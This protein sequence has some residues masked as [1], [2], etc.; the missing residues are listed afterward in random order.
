M[1]PSSA[2]RWQ[3]H[4]AGRTI[5]GEKSTPETTPAL[6]VWGDSRQGR[7]TAETYFQ[8]LVLGVQFQQCDVGFNDLAVNPIPEAAKHQRAEPSV[9]P[10]K[11]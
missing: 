4:S 2:C 9:W 8:N 1:R 6:T 7:S 3:R 5:S 10:A 11:L